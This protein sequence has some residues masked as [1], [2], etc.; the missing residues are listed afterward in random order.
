VS[1]PTFQREPSSAILLILATVAIGSLA[2]L[3]WPFLLPL[4]V[5]AVIAVLAHPAYRWCVARAGRPSLVAVLMTLFIFAFVVVPGVALL[6]ALLS[7]LEG[8]FEQAAAYVSGDGWAELG[9]NE[10]LRRIA[11]FLGIDSAEIPDLVGA[12]LGE[13]AGPI[14]SQSL[15]LVSGF[16]A[17]LFDF[18]IVVFSLFFLLR[19]GPALVERLVWLG[20]LDRE[21][22]ERLMKNARD[23]IFATVY[24][25]VGVALAQGALGGLAFGLLGIP[26]AAFWAVVMALMSLAPLVGAA[27]VWAPAGVIL[28]VQ[29]EVLR[30]LLLLAFG[31][32]V[33][34]SV[35]NFVRAWI[36]GGRTELHPLAV[37]L[38]VLG[39]VALFGAAGVFLGP[40]LFVVSVSM[41]EMAR[42]ALDERERPGGLLRRGDMIR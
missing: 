28:L 5:A 27:V 2:L 8:T 41:V 17:G 37:F 38:C 42:T 11:E 22:T 23:A 7:S 1:A 35:D 34:S 33:I 26:S 21:R 25:N 30:G 6:L 40:V 18:G 20:P 3:L 29:G 36:V 15:R 12:K 14:A 9:S 16:G 10:T 4:S 19:D 13:Q 31:A 32:L 24:G 39:G